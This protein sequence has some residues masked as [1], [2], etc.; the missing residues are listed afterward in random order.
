VIAAIV[1]TQS[2][3]AQST[4]DARKGVEQANQKF[5]AAFKAENIKDI[6]PLFTENAVVVEEDGTRFDGL[7]AIT[8]SFKEI[9][10]AMRVPAMTINLSEFGASGN[11][12]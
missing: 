4:A 5:V 3:P 11:T 7:A 9:F 2:L 8:A 10:G 6:A 1:I 12:A